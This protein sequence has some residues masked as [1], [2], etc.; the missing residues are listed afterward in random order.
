[1]WRDEGYDASSTAATQRGDW[2]KSAMHSA[3]FLSLGGRII[4]VLIDIFGNS[5]LA[6]LC[7]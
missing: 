6:G 1:M 3:V 7:K 2:N 4:M 5:S